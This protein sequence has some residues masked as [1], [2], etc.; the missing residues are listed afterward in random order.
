MLMFKRKVFRFV[1]LT[2]ALAGL[3][4]L[5]GCVMPHGGPS[6]G[7]VV[8]AEDQGKYEA[9]VPLVQVNARTGSILE[10]VGKPGSFHQTFGNAGYGNYRVTQGD[11]LDIY[12]WESAPALLFGA[13][14]LSVSDL[15]V[16]SEKLPTQIVENDGMITVPFVGRISVRGKTVREIEDKILRA[17]TPKAN[18]PQVLVHIPSRTGEE[19]TVLGDFKNSKNIP[20][21]VKR[22]RV[23][24]AVALA[25][26][27]TENYNKVMLKLTRNNVT[28]D[29]PLSAVIENAQENVTLAPGDVLVAAFKPWTFMVMGAAGKTQEIGLEAT[30]A[31]LV[32]SLSR[33][34]GLND[35]RANSSGVFVF[36]FEDRESWEKLYAE[37]GQDP[38]LKT[39]GNQESGSG[40]YENAAKVPVVYQIDFGRPDSFFAAQKFRVKDGD[41]I[42]IATASGYELQKFLKLIGTIVNPA[43]SWGN[44]ITNLTN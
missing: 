32:Q 28:V 3:C 26:G 35:D 12:I 40:L 21:S 19:V 6:Y 43:L 2:L 27:V 15:S 42:Y 44:S 38:S 13:S 11:S 14:D 9:P 22:E 10:S 16:K 4:S 39:P 1:P 41:V 8:A 17:L 25:G 7:S 24:D 34:G 23:L 31:T 5:A 29:M 33:A 37:I 20:L 36:R 30:G 18:N